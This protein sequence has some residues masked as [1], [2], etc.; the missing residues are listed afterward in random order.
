MP[1]VLFPFVLSGLSD[2]LAALGR[3]GKFL[4][5]DELPKPYDIKDNLPGIAVTTDGDFTWETV[6]K[7]DDKPK[8]A[9]KKDAPEKPEEKLPQHNDTSHLSEKGSS[10]DEKKGHVEV[11]EKPF[12]LNNVKLTVPKGAFVGIV[13]R[14]GSGKVRSRNIACM[15]GRLKCSTNLE[16]PTSSAHWGDAENQRECEV[17]LL[18]YTPLY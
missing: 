13:G 7:P 12:Q 3:I 18:I 4:T 17:S 10:V 5:A 1:L 14:V 16:L 9:G 11:E 15:I 6:E 8:K 2:A